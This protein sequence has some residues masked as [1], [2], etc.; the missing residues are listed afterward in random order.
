MNTDHCRE[1]ELSL[2]NRQE[3]AHEFLL[4]LLEHFEDK[5]IVIAEVFNLPNVFDI[6]LR[7]TT[8]CQRCFRYNETKQY[9]WLLSLHFPLGS[10][11]EAPHSV[12]HSLDIYSLMD[13]YFKLE[14]LPEHR[15]AQCA[16]VGATEK[17]L[18]IIN[19]PQIFV[20]HLSR[21]DSGLQKIDTFVNFSTEL[22]TEY[23]RN[24]NG[25]L[26]SY[27]LMGV[28]ILKESSIAEGHYISYVLIKGTWYQAD[29][30]IMTEV[31]S[32]TLS[33]LQAYILFY[34]CL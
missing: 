10:G 12:S 14:I 6:Y 4:K 19:S 17:K 24:G 32:Q 21:F 33:T 30:T 34:E 22:T 25:Q 13:S 9:L 1:A 5:L 29:D 20:I 8:T 3:D 15:C 2:N 27:R 23:I 26:L 11:E 16:F 31:S 7:S 28:I 18:S